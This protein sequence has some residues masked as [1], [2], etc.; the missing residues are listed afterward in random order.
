MRQEP[1]EG[2]SN[3]QALVLEKERE[4]AAST[5]EDARICEHMEPPMRDQRIVF[6]SVVHGKL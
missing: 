1:G 5:S 2:L 6:D 3:D 4:T